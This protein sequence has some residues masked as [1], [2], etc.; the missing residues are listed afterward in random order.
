[1]QVRWHWNCARA[2]YCRHRRCLPG[3]LPANSPRLL[4]CL[5]SLAPQ[6][7]YA[8][9]LAC[10]KSGIRGIELHLK[11]GGWGEG[12]CVWGWCVCVGG[13]GGGDWGGGGSGLSA[14]LFGSSMPP[15]LWP[16]GCTAPLPLAAPPALPHT[17]T[18]LHMC[19]L[20]ADDGPASVRREAGAVLP[21]ALHVRHGLHKGGCVHAR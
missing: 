10:Y 4:P 14:L 16:C 8:F 2:G 19:L 15:R 6:E 9:T 20:P 3:F 17:S 11:V 5:P 18:H 1:M 13:G 7:M 21:A 12:W